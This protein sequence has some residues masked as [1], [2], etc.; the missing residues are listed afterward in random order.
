MK[1]VLL[2]PAGPFSEVPRSD[3]L[4]GAIC[5]GIRLARGEEFLENVLARFRSGEP[6]FLISSAF[7]M[8]DETDQESVL[9]LPKPY[10][11]CLQAGTGEMT[12]ERLD[13]LRAWQRIEYV[14]SSVFSTIVTG[15]FSDGELLDGYGHDDGDD[16]I[17]IGDRT[18]S[19]KRQCLLPSEPDC[20]RP[21][22]KTERTRNA[23]N[24]LTSATDEALFHRDA[25]FFPDDAGLHVCVEG[26][27]ETVIDGLSVLQ[28]HGIGGDR[29][30]GYGQFRLDGVEELELPA[31][32]GDLFCSLS[33]CIPRA[34][35]MD[36]FLTA[37]YY[38]IE[39]RKGIVEN[40][41]ASPDNIWKRR[42]LA[43]AEG[44]ILPRSG[45]KEETTE[46]E[47]EADRDTPI[48]Q[49]EHERYGCNPIVADH[50]EHGVQHY[51]YSLPVGIRREAVNGST[52]DRK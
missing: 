26:D 30:I 36:E 49:E 18:Y 37:G 43:L 44:S 31:P 15:A 48:A 45:N 39:P 13:A 47:T 17:T 8:L 6:P 16:T 38:E 5:W 40:S 51:G 1:S 28:N 52:G 32:D 9:L 3:T 7:P 19:C 10:V 42:V 11:P 46:R 21:F 41:L 35:E 23:V 25:V 14:P 22:R 4:F 50:F 34:E 12:D 2:S 33:L 24:R 27:I 20:T 29:S